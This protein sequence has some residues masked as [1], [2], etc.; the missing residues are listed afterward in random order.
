MPNSSSYRRP[1]KVE[2]GG[3]CPSDDDAVRVKDVAD[4][5]DGYPEV[6]AIPFEYRDCLSVPLYGT[7]GD[8]GCIDARPCGIFKQPCNRVSTEEV[9]KDA[10]GAALRCLASRASPYFPRITMGSAKRDA[11]HHDSE[12]DART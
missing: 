11:V 10:L 4:P 8:R 12:A 7:L 9:M 1:Y 5:A 3:N 2:G 6:S